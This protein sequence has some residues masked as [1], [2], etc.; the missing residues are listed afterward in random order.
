[1]VNNNVNTDNKPKP[2]RWKVP[3]PEKTIDLMDDEMLLAID[4]GEIF[5]NFEETTKVNHCLGGKWIP[6]IK[7]QDNSVS[8]L[9]MVHE[10][11]VNLIDE[12]PNQIYSNED[13]EKE[14]VNGFV[15]C[16]TVDCNVGMVMFVTH[17][18]FYNENDIE[19]HDE[20]DSADTIGEF[21]VRDGSYKAKGE[22]K[23]FQEFSEL[24]MKLMESEELMMLVP[25][26][27]VTYSGDGDGNYAVYAKNVD[28]KAVCAFIA[29]V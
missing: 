27:V 22:N 24:Y 7:E 17:S 26:G 15:K 28:G 21:V 1:M 14:E 13:E 6:L 12:I 9:I 3:I 23:L 10:N 18:H 5:V 16:G 19:I 8:H 29:F 11:Y 20:N 4:P 25:G 2:T